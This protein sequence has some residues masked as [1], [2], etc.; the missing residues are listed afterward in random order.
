MLLQIKNIP[1]NKYPNQWCI[2]ITSISDYNER[3][4]RLRENETLNLGLKFNK[5]ITVNFPHFYYIVVNA[6]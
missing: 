6:I 4:F 5:I 3:C 1:S 2:Y